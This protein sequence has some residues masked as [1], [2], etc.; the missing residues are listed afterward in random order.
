MSDLSLPPK[1]RLGRID[2]LVVAGLLLG[3]AAYVALA[4]DL[5]VRPEEDA[6]MLLR[7][8][9]HLADGYGI[10]W[11]IGEAPVDGATDLLFMA[12]VA[13]LHALGLGLVPAAQSVGLVSHAL[14]IVGVYLG[15]R[16]LFGAPAPLALLG[17][18]FLLPG[19]GLRHLVASY[20]TPFFALWALLASLLA[21]RLILARRE[22]LR[23]FSLLF[24]LAAL[25]M[26]LSRPEGVFLGFF[27]LLAVV[28]GRGG[29]DARPI[30]ASF[31]LVFG[32]LGLAYFLWRWSYFGHPLPNP[33]YKKGGGVLHLHSL[34]MAWR[35]LWSLGWP[36]LAVLFV[37]LL[38]RGA[39]RWAFVTLG[40]VLLFV[41]LWVLIS[42][43][44]NYV[45]RFRYP[46]LP[47]ILVGWVP[48]ALALAKGPLRGVRKIPAA[49]GWALALVVGAGL[50]VLQHE[51]Y[52]SLSPRPMGLYDAALVLRDY[53]PYNYALVTTEAGLLP[54]YS[55]WRSVDAWGLNDAWIAHH[56]G[57]TEEYL[58][59]Y[60]PEVI[61][62]HAYFSPHTPQEGPRIENRS[63]GPAWYRM[64]MTLKQYAEERD[65]VLAAVYGRNAY[66]THWYYV[67]R[68]FP[69]SREIV[70]RLRGL[71]YRWDGEPTANLTPVEPDDP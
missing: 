63:L 62:F 59:R 33:F 61:V 2:A 64:V 15:P 29:A 37:G 46:V 53:A 42:N 20:G 54:L 34:R 5:G 58:D 14:T 17:A 26:G 70:E 50:G 27:L 35:D 52:G 10:V 51:R 6:A 21:F 28:Y 55:T 60:R 43:E 31:L 41:G 12:A 3:L 18:V 19:P 68:G 71:D 36:F 13:L 40:P 9:G 48:V 7:Y 66:D 38:V 44:T 24:A 8:A 67:R 32:T 22:D 30:V 1:P 57:I 4:V 45:M 65:Y 25:G 69:W 11:N 56:G 47:L 16:I 39:R 23:L 49:A